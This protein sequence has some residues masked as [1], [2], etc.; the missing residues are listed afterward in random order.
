MS[1]PLRRGVGVLAGVLLGGAIGFRYQYDQ[2]VAQLVRFGTG[3][4][5]SADGT[6]YRW[7]KHMCSSSFNGPTC[8]QTAEPPSLSL[9][10]LVPSL[11]VNSLYQ[12][13]PPLAL[14][15]GTAGVAAA[16]P[17][18]RAPCAKGRRRATDVAGGI[19]LFRVFASPEKWNEPSGFCV[20][21]SNFFVLN[22]HTFYPFQR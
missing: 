17:R 16:Q 10:V 3:H 6:G 21:H 7:C 12:F 22:S 11:L 14:I 4:A 18:R 1:S 2:R 20:Q 5:G 19:L 15:L 9:A 8:K 13:L